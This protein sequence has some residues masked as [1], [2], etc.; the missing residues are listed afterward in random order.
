MKFITTF[1]LSLIL[2]TNVF[3]ST[4]DNNIVDISVFTRYGKDGVFEA[5]LEFDI[6][7]GWH[8]FAPYEQ[9][10]GSPLIVNWKLPENTKIL[11]ETFSKADTFN[12]YGLIFDGYE[13][14]A[15]YKTTIKTLEPLDQF[16][17]EIIWQACKD[18]CIQGK[19]ELTIIP[20]DTINFDKIIN[21]ASSYFAAKP[22]EKSINWVSILLMAFIGGMILNLMPCVLPVL[23]IKI[24]SLTRVEQKNRQI[25]AWMYTL[26]VV[27]SMLAVAALLL[28]FRKFDETIGWGFQM[29][30]PWFVST[31][32]IVFIFLALMMLDIITINFVS[33]NKLALLK[34]N[35][36]KTNAFM[37]GLL[38][39]LIA[40][41]CTAPFMGA[42]VG[43]ALMSPTYIYFPIFLTLALG[44]A[45]PF[46][47][48]AYY[49]K[50]L[51]KILPKPGKW[52][53]RLKKILSIP[54]ILTCV[55]LIWVLATQIGLI[56]NKQLFDWQ[57]YSLPKVEIAIANK[58]P[59][60]I[61][62]TAKWCITCLVNKKTALQSD[63]FAKLV[64]EK[65]ILL[66]RADMT[67]QN[68]KAANGLKYYGRAGVPLYVYYNAKSDDYLILPQLLTP[69]ILQEYIQ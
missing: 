67:E 68:A 47:L 60:F 5:L 16:D 51:H 43:Y 1:C 48:L 33:L 63:E 35:G 7:P 27:V 50:L 37:T 44:Y 22:D 56:Q 69:K 26:G 46:A 28:A 30:S 31:M 4:I 59:V 11:E 25:E 23:S 53:E 65:N 45:F 39:V 34:F 18:E 12:Q 54:I 10:F 41:P 13:K 62:F 2:W 32:L 3:A 8:I 66:L 29:Q 64:K 40:S 55:W 15:F 61:D 17:A 58:Q 6:K 36:I 24:L 38:A 20:I 19:K 49:P 52:M 42:A 21:N 57:E 14:K 9:E